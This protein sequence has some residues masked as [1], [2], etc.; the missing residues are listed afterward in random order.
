MDP[1]NNEFFS[2][3]CLS[4]EYADGLTLL[5]H[6]QIRQFALIQYG[7]GQE[8]DLLSKAKLSIQHQIEEELD[9]KNTSPKKNIARYVGINSE[10]V[11]RGE[12]ATLLK[13]TLT[14][15]GKGEHSES[16]SPLIVPVTDAKSFG[17]SVL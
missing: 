6:K 2:V 14:P 16:T 10:Q 12:P 11:L 5:Q 4:Q 13:S 7:N 15:P 3:P 9:R 8:V 1:R 17:W